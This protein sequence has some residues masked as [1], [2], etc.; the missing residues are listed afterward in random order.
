MSGAGERSL[1]PEGVLEPGE[2]VRLELKPHPLFIVLDGAAASLLVVGVPLGLT[3]TD[4]SVGGSA[5]GWGVAA[6]ITAL[7]LRL[8]WRLLVWLSLIYALT[9]RRVIRIR[10]VLRVAVFAAPLDRVQ[11]VDLLLSLRERVFG[12]GSLVFSTAGTGGR[13]AAWRMIRNPVAV[14]RQV[15]QARSRD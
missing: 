15:T 14:M 11:H 6:T 2:S 5:W 9:D 12:L 10:G 4:Y 3:V 8:G 1:L 7:L 13:D